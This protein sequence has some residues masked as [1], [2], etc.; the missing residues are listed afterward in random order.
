MRGTEIIFLLNIYCKHLGLIEKNWHG[1]LGLVIACWW[2]YWKLRDPFK[3]HYMLATFGR[4]NCL[5]TI[6]SRFYQPRMSFF[7]LG[8]WT[9]QRGP[10]DN[11]CRI[12]RLPFHDGSPHGRHK[13]KNCCVSLKKN[14]P[15]PY[16][17]LLTFFQPAAYPSVLFP[18]RVNN[19]WESNL[20]VTPSSFDAKKFLH[21]VCLLVRC[22]CL[23]NK[24]YPGAG[25][26]PKKMHKK[27]LWSSPNPTTEWR[28]V[29][30]WTSPLHW[31]QNDEIQY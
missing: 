13:M 6:N 3:I 7:S 11:I 27:Q 12:H 5:W 19:S 26:T 4:N 28:R 25:S 17:I 18:K 29:K 22:D 31:P 2:D 20:S 1:G 15:Q 10:S 21:W 23:L 14:N 16:L 24:K 30:W 9:L 8:S